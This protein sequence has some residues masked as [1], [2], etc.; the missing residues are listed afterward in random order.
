MNKKI[1]DHV[2]VVGMGMAGLMAAYT[3]IQKGKNVTLLATGLGALSIASGCIDVLGYLPQATESQG[4]HSDMAPL[5]VQNPWES[6][7]QL[8]SCHPYSIIGRDA[9]EKSIQCLQE[10]FAAQ[11]ANF[12]AKAQE[13]TLVPTIIG[14]FKPT[15]MY[16]ASSDSAPIF[17]AKRALVVSVDAIRDCHP[18][19]IAQQLQKYPALK[20]V[21]FSTASLA[22]HFGAAH[23]AVSALDV[24]R[25]VDSEQGFAW[26]S[27][28]LAP[29]A[30]NVDVIIMPPILGTKL[31]QNHQRET[32]AWEKLQEKLGCAVV[33]MLSLPPA[34]GGNRLYSVL[35]DGLRSL[36]G[37]EGSGRLRIIENATIT[38][39]EINNAHCTALI[40]YAEGTEQRHEA[41]AF[42]LATGGILGGGIETEPGKAYERILG[43]ELQTPA[44]Q[45]QWAVENAFGSH[46]FTKMG[47]IVNE[48]L[49]PVDA[50]GT[51][52]VDNVHFAGRSLGVYDFAAE[53]SG[54]GV[55][56]ATAWY[57]AQQI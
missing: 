8:P 41:D 56:L 52:L 57:A 30:Q 11:G 54:N 42:I 18:Q 50:Q 53:K 37:K 5:P 35:M 3:A 49:N 47:V 32:S 23:R 10:L 17:A 4:T 43:I 46:A 2:L 31:K 39:A 13:N 51:I 21:T 36:Q 19:L 16:P 25:Y 20:E 40:S 15:Y 55:A 38:R 48:K 9:V 26:L 34:V 45:E 7:A 44:E 33:E 14:T 1:N 28:A 29:L 6:L 27:A 24:A 12:L 22:S